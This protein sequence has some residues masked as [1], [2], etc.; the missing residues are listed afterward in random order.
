MRLDKEVL[1]E[2]LRKIDEEQLK[3]G[4]VAFLLEKWGRP[5]PIVVKDQGDFFEL[6]TRGFFHKKMRI[7]KEEVFPKKPQGVEG[8]P[9]LAELVDQLYEVL[10]GDASP[11]QEIFQG[12]IGGCPCFPPTKWLGDISEA[13]QQVL[14]ENAIQDPDLKGK[15]ESVWRQLKI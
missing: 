9:Q 1:I 8:I 13:F 14:S 11:Y 15:V 6:T 7:S 4:P 10:G 5:Y 2:E 12:I 3:T